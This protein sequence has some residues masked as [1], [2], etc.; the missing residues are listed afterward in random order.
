MLITFLKNFFR[1]LTENTQYIHITPANAQKKPETS[2]GR[3]SQKNLRQ[4]IGN[5]KPISKSVTNWKRIL[6]VSI[7]PVIDS[8]TFFCKPKSLKGLQIAT[9]HSPVP[10]TTRFSLYVWTYVSIHTFK[11]RAI[12]NF[13][14]TLYYKIISL[15][16][17]NLQIVNNFLLTS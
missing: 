10:Y 7:T 9:L 17:S 2:D 8:S 1:V 12:T 11:V 5:I 4:V 6:Y 3:G 16:I 14:L 13:L 15:I